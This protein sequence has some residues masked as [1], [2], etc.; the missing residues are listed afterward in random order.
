MRRSST[1]RFQR[2]LL[3]HADARGGSE[4]VRRHARRLPLYLEGVALHHTL[5]AALRPQCELARADGDAPCAAAAQARADPVPVAAAH[6]RRSRAS[7]HVHPDVEPGPSLQL[8]VSPSELVRAGDLRAR[9]TTTWRCA[10]PI[11]RLLR[12]A[13]GDRALVYVRNHG[14]S[15][16][17]HGNYTDAALK[18]WARSI[19]GWRRQ[20][21]DVWCFFDNDVARR[22]GR[23][24]TAARFLDA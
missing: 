17:Y 11:T 22:T 6:G 8:R 9:A 12:A 21:R 2:A 24:S 1:P 14:P 4:L 10:S 20:G 16:R 5:E 15:G 7:R 13:G 3:S 18:D 19:D 23:C